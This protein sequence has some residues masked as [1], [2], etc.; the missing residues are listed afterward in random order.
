MLKYFFV[1]VAALVVVYVVSSGAVFYYHF[2]KGTKL[3]RAAVVFEK[4]IPSAPYHFLFLGDSTAV[5]VGASDPEHSLAGLFS[6]DFPNAAIE[7]RGVSGM[8]VHGLLETFQPKPHERYDLVVINIGGNDIVRFTDPASYTADIKTIFERARSISDNVVVLHGGDIVHVPFFPWPVGYAYLGKTE[9]LRGV[10][11]EAASKT[12]VHYI[13]IY[14]AEKTDPRSSV[15]SMWFA[16][17]AFH[18]NNTS[19][20][21]WYEQI[22]KEMNANG[23]L[24]DATKTNEGVS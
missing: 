5:G 10:F 6:K 14:S 8:R 21:F 17:D 2:Q 4:D 23:I 18:P 13:D 24:Q 7:N 19:Y 12:G 3:A 15:R 11:I 20:Q 9:K 16:A 22:R 1:G